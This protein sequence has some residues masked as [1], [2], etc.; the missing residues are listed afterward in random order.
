VESIVVN[1]QR[2]EERM[3][4]TELKIRLEFLTPEQLAAE[5]IWSGDE[6][7]GKVRS[8]W[9]ADE[10]WIENDD[11]DDCIP[12]SQIDGSDP[13]T[14]GGFHLDGKIAISAGTPMLL[15]N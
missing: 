13:E 8:L 4:F 6:R 14:N 2:K 7:G 1:H 9:L 15:V 12:R 11:G 10:D 3:T 5:V